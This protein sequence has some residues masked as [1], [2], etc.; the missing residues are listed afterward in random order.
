LKLIKE[1]FALLNSNLVTNI[2]IIIRGFVVARFLGPT[3]YGIIKFLEM[4]PQVSK[5]GD[6]GFTTV[7]LREIPYY[8]GKENRDKEIL[9][10]DTAYTAELIFTLILVSIFISTIAFFNEKII[11]IGVISYSLL[12]F[13]QKILR[14]FRTEAIIQKKFIVL[15]KIIMI[16]GMISSIGVIA[17]VPFI[18]IYSIFFIPPFSLF[19]TILFAK[20]NLEIPY[21]FRII[22]KELLRQTRIGIPLS[23]NSILT[24]LYRYIEKISIGYFLGI[25]FVGFYGLATVFMNLVVGNSSLLIRLVQPRI[26]EAIGRGKIDDALYTVQYSTKCILYILSV[27]IGV[28]LINMQ[29]LIELVLPNYK[30]GIFAY[31]GLLLVCYINMSYAFIRTILYAPEVDKLKELVYI[32][33]SSVIVFILILFSL[34]I[35]NRIT[36]E[37]I[38]IADI[39]GF[40][41][42]VFPFYYIFFFHFKLTKNDIFTYFKTVFFPIL[43]ILIL[44][45]LHLFYSHHLIGNIF[46]L[47]IILIIISIRYLYTSYTTFKLIESLSTNNN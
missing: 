39:I 42:R 9:A 7:A 19:L 46:F 44:F 3:Q 15:G 10:R 25:R 28:G 36:F 16:N 35:F 37:N 18:G 27:I 12:L 20:L 34:K 38:I 41:F 8:R 26:Y 4:I 32:S 31:Y 14:I 11:I 23:I 5:Y 33:L 24:G 30:D 45:Y 47:N 13:F 6:L 21:K 29:W 43:P 22:K 1:S 2:L 40:T 17:T